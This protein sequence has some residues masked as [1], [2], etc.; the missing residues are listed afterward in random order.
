MYEVDSVASKVRHS[1]PRAADWRN[2][3]AV[4]QVCGFVLSSAVEIWAV[5]AIFRYVAAP[6]GPPTD[7]TR[8]KIL[9]P[10]Q[11]SPGY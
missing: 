9:R 3:S 4:S 7:A 11:P 1:F 10:F 5:V 6:R 2:C 8:Q